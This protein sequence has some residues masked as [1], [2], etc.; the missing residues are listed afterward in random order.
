MFG[1][2]RRTAVRRRVMV[3]LLDGR[4]LGGV[5]WARRGPLLVLRD[6]ALFEPGGDGPVAIDGEAVVERARVSFVQ[7]LSGG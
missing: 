3:N 4:A 5:L 6:V 2:W 1:A 7:V